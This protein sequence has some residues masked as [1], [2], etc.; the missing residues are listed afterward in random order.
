M[1]AGP[2]RHGRPR[3]PAG[4]LAMSRERPF[5]FAVFGAGGR[6]RNLSGDIADRIVPQQHQYP[7]ILLFRSRYL[8][9]LAVRRRIEPTTVR[10]R[11]RRSP[12]LGPR[13][14]PAQLAVPL[15][16]AVDAEARRRRRCPLRSSRRHR[17]GL[18]PAL[19]FGLW[20]QPLRRTWTQAFEEVGPG[21]PGTWPSPLTVMDLDQ[22][23]VNRH[24]RVRRCE[25]DHTRRSDHAAI[26]VSLDLP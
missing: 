12:P 19:R 15:A 22:V 17:R 23:W 8:H 6:G 9:R 10:R 4:G 18:Q 13:A 7:D 2:D 26:R 16:T 25:L 1:G 5:P 11:G 24:V 20:F 3:C 14:R 21:W